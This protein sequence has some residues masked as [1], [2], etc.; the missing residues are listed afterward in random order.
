VADGHLAPIKAYI[1]KLTSLMPLDEPLPQAEPGENW[2]PLYGLAG[3]LS[4]QA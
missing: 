2:E 1:D 4:T 3:T